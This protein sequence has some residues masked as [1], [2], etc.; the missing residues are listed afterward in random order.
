M[1]DRYGQ[2]MLEDIS[3]ITILEAFMIR[4]RQFNSLTKPAVKVKDTYL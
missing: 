4:T 2:F 1:E 3:A